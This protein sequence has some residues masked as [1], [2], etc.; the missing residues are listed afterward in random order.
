MKDTYRSMWQDLEGGG[1]Q[2]HYDELQGCTKGD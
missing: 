1:V 2:C